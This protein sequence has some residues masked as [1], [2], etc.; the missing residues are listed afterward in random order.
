MDKIMVLIIVTLLLSSCGFNSFYWSPEAGNNVY[1]N[2]VVGYYDYAGQYP[3]KDTP[4]EF[5]FGP[6]NPKAQ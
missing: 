4:A 5:Y 1:T 6:L 3:S 2:E